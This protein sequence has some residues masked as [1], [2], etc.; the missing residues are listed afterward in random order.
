MTDIF[1]LNDLPSNKDILNFDRYVNPLIRIIK[2]PQTKTPFTIGI[3]GAW[4]SGKSTLLNFL[5]AGLTKIDEPR[6]QCI[7]FNPWLYREEKNLL[8]P[9]LH[10]IKDAF[11]KDP[12]NRFVETAKKIGVILARLGTALV[13]KTVTANQV[14]LGDIEG[15]EKVFAEQYEHVRSAIRDLKQDLQK[16]I[17]EITENEEKGR[18][19]IFID[20]LDRCEPDQIVALLEGLKLFLDLERCFFVLALDDEVIHRAIQIKYTNFDFYKERKPKIGQEYLEK[21]IQLPLYLFPLDNEQIEDFLQKLELPDS[22]SQQAA[23]LAELMFPNP[24]KIKRILNLF[25]LNLAVLSNN[26][27]LRQQIKDETL[28]RLIVLQVQDYELYLKV[29]RNSELPEYLSKL[30]RGNINLQ[31]DAD[32]AKLGDRRN[33]IK[34]LCKEYYQPGSW[35]EKIFKTEDSFPKP[36]ELIQYFDMLGRS[37]R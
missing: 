30:Y 35:I 18:L 3:F 12:S 10:T 27:K 6:F 25:L 28:A 8:V 21:M 34:E 31:T 1:L 4:G 16:A 11:E 37:T 23:L 19:V 14:T 7:Y 15:H 29:V 13:L 36:T 17:N 5:N 32:W 2:N 33:A 9:L 20:D 24:R 22:V 26:N